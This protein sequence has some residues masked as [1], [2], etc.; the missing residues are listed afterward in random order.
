MAKTEF[1]LIRLS[2]ENKER[3]ERMARAQYFRPSVWARSVL[4]K[5]VDEWEREQQLGEESEE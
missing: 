1:L 4:L 2:K 3:I 5:A